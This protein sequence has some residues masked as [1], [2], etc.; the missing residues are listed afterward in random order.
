[1]TKEAKRT[2]P[3]KLEI[4]SDEATPP[5]TETTFERADSLPDETLAAPEPTPSQEA[6]DF[7]AL[8]ESALAPDDEDVDLEA[9]M[10]PPRFITVSRKTAPPRM[11]PIRIFPKT[12]ETKTVYMLCVS[13]EAQG[14]DDQDTYLLSQPVRQLLVGNPA[15]QRRVRRFQIRLG[16]TS[17]GRPFFLEVNL[18]DPGIWGQSRRDLVARAEAEWI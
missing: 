5:K 11:I 17:L 8:L 12:A 7:D 15:F 2:K 14:D 6:D 13:R 10:G 18:D 4:I 9:E 3:R 16:M 1:M